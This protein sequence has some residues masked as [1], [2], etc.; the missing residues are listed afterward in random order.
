MNDCRDI[1]QISNW[2]KKECDIYNLP[3]VDT[4]YNRENI[5]NEFIESLCEQKNKIIG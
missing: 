4:A 5:I 1:V 2:I 3:Y